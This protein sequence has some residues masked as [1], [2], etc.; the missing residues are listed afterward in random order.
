[1]CG[2]YIKRPFT[3]YR[4]NYLYVTIRST[5]H[6]V[7]VDVVDGNAVDRRGT[8]DCDT[9]KEGKLPN[10]E[11]AYLSLLSSTEESLS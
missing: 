2:V 4:I 3:G 5:C 10:V 6:K 1:M 8:V 7:A 9:V 11:D